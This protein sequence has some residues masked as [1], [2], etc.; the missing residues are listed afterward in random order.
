MYTLP[1]EDSQLSARERQRGKKITR[2]S[3]DRTPHKYNEGLQ[4][5]V[6]EGA[7]VI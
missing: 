2:G 6:G 7:T 3:I 4:N 1:L 5:K